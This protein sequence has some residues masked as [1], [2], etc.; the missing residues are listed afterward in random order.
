MQGGGPAASPPCLMPPRN[1]LV[2]VKEESRLLRSDRGHTAGDAGRHDEGYAVAGSPEYLGPHP[3]NRNNHIGGS[4][5]V[6][7]EHDGVTDGSVG[8]GNARGADGRLGDLPQVKDTHG[9]GEGRKEE[10]GSTGVSRTGGCDA[11]VFWQ[12]P[13]HTAPS[14]LSFWVRGHR[15][16]SRL[17]WPRPFPHP[18]RTLLRTVPV[19]WPGPAPGTPATRPACRSGWPAPT[20]HARPGPYSAP[21]QAPSPRGTARQT[22]TQV[23]AGSLPESLEPRFFIF[24]THCLLFLARHDRSI[25]ARGGQCESQ[26]WSFSGVSV[27]FWWSFS[28]I[29]LK[30]PD[31]RG[32]CF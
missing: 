25:P 4:Q 1:K 10:P 24:I 17:C 2:H 28:V 27:E 13:V 8:G 20:P 18:A 30:S 6:T 29:L 23:R 5:P 26:W 11:R 22:P 31:R 12:I 19:P 32:K 7:G 9:H 3:T 15:G 16:H 21:A 14:H